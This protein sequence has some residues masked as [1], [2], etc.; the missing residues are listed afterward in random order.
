MMKL[1]AGELIQGVAQ[2]LTSP[3][4]SEVAI[5]YFPTALNRKINLTHLDFVITWG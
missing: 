3:Q 2:L 1:F 5:R 4:K